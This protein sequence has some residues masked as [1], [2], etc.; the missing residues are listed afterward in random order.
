MKIGGPIAKI[1]LGSHYGAWFCHPGPN[2]I[3]IS[4]T[5]GPLP[6]PCV[7]FLAVL[8]HSWRCNSWR[9]FQFLMNGLLKDAPNVIRHVRLLIHLVHPTPALFILRPSYKRL[10]LM[11]SPYYVTILVKYQRWERN[12]I[13]IT[14]K[15]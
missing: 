7:T 8:R 5:L 6:Y 10:V 14:L 13:I 4:R 12:W 2:L 3:T 9:I 15:L 1:K 11:N